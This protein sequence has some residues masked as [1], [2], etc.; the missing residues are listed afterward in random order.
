MYSKHRTKG[1]LI[2]MLTLLLFC[3]VE[4]WGNVNE[5]H[6]IDII[7]IEVKPAECERITSEIK[8]N[9]QENISL[10]KWKNYV[11]ITCQA[12]NGKR[13][14]RKFMETWPELAVKV[15]RMP[16]YKFKSSER[17]PGYKMAKNWKHILLTSNLVK[18]KDLQYEYMQHHQH[19]FENWPEVSAG[20]CNGQFQQLLLYRNGRQLMLVISIPTGTSLDDL[21]PKTVKNNPR[22][23][24]W[25]TIMARYQENITGVDTEEK[26]VFLEKIWSS[27]E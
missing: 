9:L 15:F 6:D 4:G 27:G 17:C 13:I 8:E 18:D 26:W 20:F 24:Q 23:V 11:A 12:G 21:N 22:M 5:W 19:Q 1:I 16:F 10:Y 14:S 7:W 2:L 25:N 3:G